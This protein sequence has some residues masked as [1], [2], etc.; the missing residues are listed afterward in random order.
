[1]GSILLTPE[2]YFLQF[3][4][5]I[6]CSLVFGG[7]ASAADSTFY[8][9][10]DLRESL[11]K[12]TSAPGLLLFVLAWEVILCR[13]VSLDS[14]RRVGPPS[15]GPTQT[16]GPTMPDSPEGT[17][18]TER[19]RFRYFVIVPRF[20][21]FS[22]C[23][24][25]L[26]CLRLQLQK[27]NRSVSRNDEFVQITRKDLIDLET[28]TYPRNVILQLCDEHCRCRFDSRECSHLDKVTETDFFLYRVCP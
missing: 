1:M 20:M 9:W 15:S 8:A 19:V 22:T 18:G 21:P 3:W 14:F 10:N 2:L 13:R 23:F 26:Q 17:K 7:C 28:T 5:S 11:A 6:L 27:Q 16:R 4:Q 12:S 24:H 25:T